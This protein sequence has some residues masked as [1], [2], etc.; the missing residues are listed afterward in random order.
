[1]PQNKHARF[2][3]TLL[4][5]ALAVGTLV[6]FLP[7]LAPFLLALLLA[8][9]LERPVAAL[10]RLF[11][12]HRRPAALLCTLLLTGLLAGGLWI[13][14]RRACYELGLLLERF[15]LLLG[16]L[17][18]LRDTAEQYIYRFLVALPVDTQ[19][20]LRTTIGDL[21]SRG[22]TIPASLY[23]WLLGAASRV[24]GAIPGI[25]L[26]AFTTILA[27]YFISSGRPA[28]SDA[29][30]RLIPE[31]WRALAIEGKVRLVRAA[32]SWLRVQGL[33]LIVCF[34]LLS[35]GLL[36][37]GVDLAFL[38]AAGTALLDA[39]PIFGV[40]VVLIPWAVASFFGGNYS[41]GFG[42]L[43]LYMILWLA[44]GVLEP[45]LMGDSIGLPPLF[46]LMA[47][48]GGFTFFGI[49]G[50]ILAPLV[51]AMLRQLLVGVKGFE[52]Q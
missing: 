31:K 28:L 47:M 35:A 48:Y 19:E 20:T 51:A 45:K 25:G 23:E 17:P 13:L 16:R 42:F 40:G 36:L 32:G 11:A 3:L 1:M 6:L 22:V 49:A 21:L 24:T 27:V 38:I 37:L 39:L 26:F 34:V 30:F 29:V 52:V 2:L 5:T 44:R 7:W 43:I 14:F 12:G 46:A 41:L 15:P 33:L 50:M 9:L 8:A 10:T 4:Y 18:S